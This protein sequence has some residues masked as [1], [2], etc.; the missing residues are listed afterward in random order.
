MMIYSSVLIASH[1]GSTGHPSLTWPVKIHTYNSN[2]ETLGLQNFE[3]PFIF[4]HVYCVFSSYKH[5]IG[6]GSSFEVG[7]P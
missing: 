5:C 2:E 1:C 6:S 4:I 7:G 3:I